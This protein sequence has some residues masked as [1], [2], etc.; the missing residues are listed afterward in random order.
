ME[1][2]ATTSFGL[3]AVVARELKQL[4]YGDS[5]S[6]DGR[7]SFQGDEAAI[8]RT[9]LWLRSAERVHVKLGSFVARDFDELFEKT[10]ALPWSDWLPV[11][12]EFP[13]SGTSIRSKLASVRSCQSIVK[14][15]IVEQMKGTYRRGRFSERG[16]VYAIEIAILKDRVTLSID[17]SGTGLHKRG[18]RKLT[19]TAPLRETL[20]A[21]LVQ[22]SY[23]NRE[24]PF[25]DPFCG[26]GTIPIEAALIGRNVAPGLNR[27]FAAE[28]WLRVPKRLWAEARAEARDLC[29][30]A[31][32][33]TLVAT[34][35]DDEA[36]SMARY[37]AK[38]AG[39]GEDIH[40]Q[41][42]DVK[43][44]TTQRK[45]GC[46]IANPPYGQRMGDSREV[47]GLYVAL[48]RALR[49]LDTWSAYVLT[50]LPEFEKV[51]GRKADR[52]RKL[53]NARI[54]CTY[55]QFFGPPPPR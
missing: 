17:T 47:R 44:L 54:P 34:D 9:N 21:G 27:S 13:V 20:A 10:R 31:P 24:R 3:E 37:H 36:L 39:V 16:A 42:A 25:L 6:E 48:G 30:P 52:R 35:I 2:M 41:Q 26:T 53:H 23:W 18:Y 29:R 4:G 49:G 55:Y 32:E 14:K 7:V 28:D 50:A 51:V 11:D 33:F 12:A 43:D 46:L 40:F 38:L 8:C 22:L 45:Y 19:G 5:A 1:L 15:A